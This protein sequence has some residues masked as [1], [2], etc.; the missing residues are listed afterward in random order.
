MRTDFISFNDVQEGSVSADPSMCVPTLPVKSLPDEVVESSLHAQLSL[1]LPSVQYKCQMRNWNDETAKKISQLTGSIYSHRAIS[2]AFFRQGNASTPEEKQKFFEAKITTMED[3]I[4]WLY[5]TYTELVNFSKTIASS[6]DDL[7][8]KWQQYKMESSTQYMLSLASVLAELH[9]VDIVKGTKLSIQS[10]INTFQDL[11]VALQQWE[12]SEYS[13]ELMG[14]YRSSYSG[15]KQLQSRLERYETMEEMLYTVLVNLLDLYDRKDKSL[16]RLVPVKR[17]ILKAIPVLLYLLYCQSGKCIEKKGVARA[18][19]LLKRNPVLPVAGDAWMS[20]FGLLSTL[21]GFETKYHIR[22]YLLPHEISEKNVQATDLDLDLSAYVERTK[23]TY[24]S[25]LF[26]L[27]KCVSQAQKVG[28]DT[29]IIP[30]DL[31]EQAMRV[32]KDILELVH[33]IQW[34]LQSFYYWKI[35]SSANHAVSGYSAEDNLSNKIVSLFTTKEKLAILSLMQILKDLHQYM[36]TREYLLFPILSASIQ[37]RLGAFEEEIMAK[38]KHSKKGQDY[39]K[40]LHDCLATFVSNPSKDRKLVLG[41]GPTLAQL[42]LINEIIAEMCFEVS[43]QQK[44]KLLKESPNS[45]VAK[46]MEGFSM[47][48]MLFVFMMDECFC[49]GQA[50][51]T[52]YLWLHEQL[53]DKMQENKSSISTSLPW[54]LFEAQI[55]AT[56]QDL[57]LELA[58]TPMHIYNKAA[59]TNLSKFGKQYIY[60][61]LE[62]EADLAYERMAFKIATKIYEIVKMTVSGQHLSKFVNEDVLRNENLIPKQNIRGMV[63]PKVHNLLGRNVNFRKLIA[64]RVNKLFRE[65]LDYLMERFEALDISQGILEF[66]TGYHILEAAHS[67][68]KEY[69]GID[70]WD[71]IAKEMNESTSNMS[72]GSRLCVYIYKELAAVVPMHYNYYLSGAKFIEDMNA[73]GR[74]MRKNPLPVLPSPSFLFGHRIYNETIR[75]ISK[76]HSGI[77]NTMHF[78]CLAQI[79]SEEEIFLVVQKLIEKAYKIVVK[80]LLPNFVDCMERVE[81]SSCFMDIEPPDQVIRKF[82]AILKSFESQQDEADSKI[83]EDMKTFGNIMM[84]I[85]HLSNVKNTEHNS[86]IVLSESLS[87]GLAVLRSSHSKGLN[88]DDLSFKEIERNLEQDSGGESKP[89]GGCTSLFAYSVKSL[90]QLFAEELSEIESKRK[91]TAIFNAI[92]ISFCQ[93]NRDQVQNIQKYGDTVAFGFVLLTHV[94]EVINPFFLLECVDIVSEREEDNLPAHLQF[95]ADNAQHF[96]KTSLAAK[97]LIF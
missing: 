28:L 77:L 83:F 35:S 2:K 81:E 44:R 17:S 57:E 97:A 22:M 45:G 3:E 21:D 93:D 8:S 11:A 91:L 68:L 23:P 60:D 84:I 96:Y 47:D 95:L 65:N 20:S 10:D 25:L 52:S 88:I 90:K 92:H 49:F 4:K 18:V 89:G 82:H 51:D 40:Y 61:E 74:D 37:K 70:S 24:N 14:F 54:K 72:F 30:D 38:V 56:R 55:E 9:S 15:I 50:G 46:A 7:N 94:F 36:L 19:G 76:M 12:L 78:Q 53:F 73:R 39:F 85:L 67:T 86:N 48:L 29:N 43:H 75:E 69:L 13:E 27:C 64:Q 34:Q 62:T 41:S 59:A 33:S 31:A 58:L 32:Y 80:S 5:D 79:L 71:T 1:Q 63:S 16:S 87:R 26:Q 42:I 66:H 6:L